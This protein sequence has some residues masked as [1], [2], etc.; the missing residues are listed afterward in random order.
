VLYALPLV[1]GTVPVPVVS[2]VEQATKLNKAAH[3]NPVERVRWWVNRFTVALPL[4]Q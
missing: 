2:V 1:R 3:A 4:F